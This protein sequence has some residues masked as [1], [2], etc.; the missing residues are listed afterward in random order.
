MRG[1]WAHQAGHERSRDGW[2]WLRR[3]KPRIAKCFPMAAF[4]YVWKEPAHW[5]KFSNSWS[6]ECHV[7][8]ALTYK[9]SSSC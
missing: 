4:Y 1:S 8:V 5:R 3:R 2:F 7:A 9:L 6:A